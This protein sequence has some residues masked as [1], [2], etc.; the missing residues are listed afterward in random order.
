L[1]FTAGGFGAGGFGASSLSL[2]IAAGGFGLR[3]TAGGFS[4]GGFSAGRVGS[5]GGFGL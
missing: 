1:R 3:I 2:G 5:A 4:A